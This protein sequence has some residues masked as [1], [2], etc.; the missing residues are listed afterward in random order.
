MLRNGR[1]SVESR[2]AVVAIVGD[3]VGYPGPAM[4]REWVRA[5]ADMPVDA[6]DS[7]LLLT[8]VWWLCSR[9]EVCIPSR[10]DAGSMDD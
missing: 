9:M 5:G 6:R 3:G 7:C 8:M 2:V 10:V 4:D 1:S